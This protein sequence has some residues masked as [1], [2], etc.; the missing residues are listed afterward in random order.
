MT[1]GNLLETKDIPNVKDSSLAQ[2]FGYDL[3]FEG[4]IVQQRPPEQYI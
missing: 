1:H 4:D 2:W 3:I